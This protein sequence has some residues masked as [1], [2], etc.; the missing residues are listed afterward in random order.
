MI[1]QCVILNISVNKRIWTLNSCCF[2]SHNL[3]KLLSIHYL[4]VYML[5]NP[6]FYWHTDWGGHI[7]L[8]VS[9]KLFAIDF[10]PSTSSD[11][12]QIK[13]NLFS[14][15]FF[16]LFLVHSR[17]TW[18][19]TTNHLLMLRAVRVSNK[20]KSWN[21]NQMSHVW[22]WSTL[23][24]HCSLLLRPPALEPNRCSKG[25]ES[26]Q[27]FPGSARN[28]WAHVLKQNITW[29]TNE[30]EDAIRTATPLS[31]CSTSTDLLCTR[32]RGV[33]MW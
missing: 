10:P 3:F 14:F 18:T 13:T 17:K 16:L 9:D 22:R 30:G 31:E 29:E 23:P 33:C 1:Q 26:S 12:L 8:L 27:E 5:S 24:S 2:F 21:Q 11:G 20:F 15:F 32:C 28:M 7:Y 4:I 6:I 25:S 19:I